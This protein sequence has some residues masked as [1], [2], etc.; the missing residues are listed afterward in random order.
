MSHLSASCLLRSIIDKRYLQQVAACFSSQS[1]ITIVCALSSHSGISI[2]KVRAAR[3]LVRPFIAPR[4][5]KEYWRTAQDPISQ[6]AQSVHN[7][8]IRKPIILCTFGKELEWPM[9]SEPPTPTR[10]P[11]NQ[12]RQIQYQLVYVRNTTLLN[13]W[14]WGRGVLFHRSSSALEGGVPVEPAHY[15]IS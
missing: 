13:L 7:L 2:A 12:F 4:S 11:D 1:G 3:P 6:P 14:S 5:W 10:A 15:S 8:R 9:Q